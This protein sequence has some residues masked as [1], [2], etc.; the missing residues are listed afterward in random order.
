MQNEETTNE[1][2]EVAAS[3]PVRYP[4]RNIGVR[5]DIYSLEHEGLVLSVVEQIVSRDPMVRLPDEPRAAIIRTLEA[6]LTSLDNDRVWNDVMEPG[7]AKASRALKVEMVGVN[8]DGAEVD[9]LGK[10]T[11]EQRDALALAVTPQ[12]PT[13]P[14]QAQQMAASDLA[15]E[16]LGR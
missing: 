2:P 1:T 5:I 9:L 11:P 10:L 6:L 15:D 4:V 3:E 13:R 12:A 16:L 8:N 7:L 14:S